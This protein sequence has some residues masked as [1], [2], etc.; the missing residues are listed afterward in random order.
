LQFFEVPLRTVPTHWKDWS[1]QHWN[2]KLLHYCFVRKASENSGQGIPSTEEDLVFITGD[3]E[4]EPAD[5]AQAL[6]N[7]VREYSV[8]HGLSP[9]RLLIQRLESWN[10]KSASPPR[11][12]AFLWTTCLI[13]QGFP[14]PFEK[15]EFHKRYARDE[16]YGSNERQHLSKNLPAAWIQLAKWLDRTDIFDG[17]EHRRLVLPTEDPQRS[18]I[19]HSWKLSFP[20]RADRKRM[21]DVLER[22]KRDSTSSDGIDIQLISRVY[23]Q[24]DFTPEFTDAL[25]QQ[26]DHLQRGILAEEWF[27]AII[28]REIESLGATQAQS[29]RQGVLR[30]SIS[31]TLNVMLYLDDDECYLELVLPSQSIPV[32]KARRLSHK[33]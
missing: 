30:A 4:S 29:S 6:V 26:I 31:S 16:V 2:I 1:E 8:N 19:S 12:F 14:S 15:G 10:Y 11:F 22:L 3:R 7:R 23:H 28:Q 21:H 13:A 24:G 32:E 33:T 5:L 17:Q 25:K 9:A 27:S 18:I 20:C